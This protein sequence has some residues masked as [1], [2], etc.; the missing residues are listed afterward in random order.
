MEFQPSGLWEEGD[1]DLGV[2]GQ[3]EERDIVMQQ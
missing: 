3:G 2:E 1:D